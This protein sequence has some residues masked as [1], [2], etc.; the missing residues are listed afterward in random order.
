MAMALLLASLVCGGVASEDEALLRISFSQRQYFHLAD[1][2]TTL[3]ETELMGGGEVTPEFRCTVPSDKLLVEQSRMGVRTLEVGAE[4]E[5]AGGLLSGFPW[6]D[7]DEGDQPELILSQVRLRVCD[8]S[9]IGAE[10]CV[11]HTAPSAGVLAVSIEPELFNNSL[12]VYSVPEGAYGDNLAI[13]YTCLSDGEAVVEL[14]LMVEGFPTVQCMRWRKICSAG[15]SSLRIKEE[16]VD[17]FKDGEFQESWAEL[18]QHEGRN[19]AASQ[20]QLTWDGV[21]RLRE[22]VVESDQTLVAVS[23]RG[24]SLLF[25]GDELEVTVD[26]L[27]LTVVYECNHDGHAEIML[28]LEK[29]TLEGYKPEILNLR[30][31]KTCGL[32]AFRHV[33][34]FIK[35]DAFS[36]RTRAMD[37]DGL[38]LP[39]FHRPCRVDETAQIKAMGRPKAGS[40]SKQHTCNLENE[41]QLTLP[42]SER[43]T[44]LVLMGDGEM[45]S[46]PVFQPKPDVSYDKRIMQV[47]VTPPRKSTSHSPKWSKSINVR[48]VCLKE[49]TG[50]VM[51]TL[52]LL[53][54]KTVDLAWRKQC[55]EPKPHVSKALTAPQAMFITTGVLLVVVMICCLVVSA[56]KDDS[57]MDEEMEF[58][59]RR[60]R[61][62]N[63]ATKLGRDSEHDG[64]GSEDGPHVPAPPRSASKLSRGD[65]RGD[66]EFR[67]DWR[68]EIERRDD[69]P[70]RRRE[71]EVRHRVD[72]HEH[73]PLKHSIDIDDDAD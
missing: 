71:T 52:H 28:A 54:Y 15:W 2:K 1:Q 45:V 25:A 21:V 65:S 51:V 26:P 6:S 13:V 47:T 66:P 55:M 53:S 17:V 12:G 14:S 20:F 36:N 42:E 49:G 63:R 29:V 4:F 24:P 72:F 5:A 73:A 46:E 69:A 18:M 7:D 31:K 9:T 57:S 48:Y 70:P 43:L 44:T 35:S 32:T 67:R 30:W 23:V 27:P 33:E 61:S 60:G 56:C 59:G 37:H 11:D 64:Y 22:P 34:M 50:V 62:L 38:V 19:L 16:S 39:G 8:V 41:Y 10:K 58:V 3:E 40:P 68:R